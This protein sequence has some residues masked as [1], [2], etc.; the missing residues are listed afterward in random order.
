LKNVAFVLQQADLREPG[1]IDVI[2]RHFE[3]MAREKIGFAPPMFAVSAHDILLAQSTGSEREKL[4]VEKQ[5]GPLR[6]QINLVV[7]QSGGRMQKLRS[8]CQIAQVLLHDISA[9]LRKSLEVTGRDQT[10]IARVNALLQTRKEQTQ[11][12][13]TDL[14]RQIEQTSRQASAQRLPLLKDTLAPAQLLNMMRG[15]FPQQRDFQLQID[16]ASRDSIERQVEETAQLLERDLREIWPQLH[17]LVDQQLASAINAE[18]P[19]TPPDFARQRRELLHAA[20]MAMSARALESK[21]DD[22]LVRLFR[23]TAMWLRV[24]AGAVVVCVL[25]ALLASS[26][27]PAVAKIAAVAA[28]ITFLLGGGLAIYRRRKILRAYEQQMNKRVAELVEMI[29]WQF[30]ETIDSFHNQIAARFEP[31]AAHCAAQHDK[32]EPLFRRADELQR[33]FV[34]IAEQLR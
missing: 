3:D 11:R 1:A 15:R 8:V 33:K 26:T 27:N 22:D 28:V 13:I 32:F 14:L 10:R 29:S 6:E 31:L 23:G 4:R 30:N 20:H 19:H 12:H 25:I 34:Q 24:A 5:V 17:D 16:Q 21:S 2:Q 18:V 9:E 7:A